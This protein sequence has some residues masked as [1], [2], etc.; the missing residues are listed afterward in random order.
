MTG[1][2]LTVR[3]SDLLTVVPALNLKLLIVAPRAREAKVMPELARP[4]FKKIGLSGHCFLPAE[5]L[6]ALVSK[7]EHLGGHTQPSVLDTKAVEL[8]TELSDNATL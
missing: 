3:M 1:G 4:T 5:E 8:Q 2:V 7:I 6:K